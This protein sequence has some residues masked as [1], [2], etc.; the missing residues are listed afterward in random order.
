MMRE[1]DGRSKGCAFV[2]Y[3][4]KEAAN[5]ACLQ[6]NGSLILPGA[7]RNLVVKFA[8][9]SEPRNRQGAP[10]AMAAVQHVGVRYGQGNTPHSGHGMPSHM[11]GG[12]AHAAAAAGGGFSPRSSMSLAE[13][14]HWM[15]MQAATQGRAQ[16][17]AQQGGGLVSPQMVGMNGNMAV[18]P[19]MG[20]SH[21][22]MSPMGSHYGGNSM[23]GM[24]MMHPGMTSY[25][26]SYTQQ[27]NGSNFM[28]NQYTGGSAYHQQQVI[29]QVQQSHS[30]GGGAWQSDGQGAG[31]YGLIEGS[32][33]HADSAAEGGKVGAPGS[34]GCAC[35]GMGGIGMMHNGMGACGGGMGSC[36]GNGGCAFGPSGGMAM[37]DRQMGSIGFSDAMVPAGQSWDRLY[38]SNLPRPFTEAE[39][40]QLFSQFGPLV[41]VHPH[42]RPDGS[43]K[44]SFFVNFVNA[45]DGQ[46]A[47]RALHNCMLNGAMKPMTVRPST[48]R[49]KTDAHVRS[50]NVAQHATPATAAAGG[51]GS[52]NSS[53]GGAGSCNANDTHCA[54]TG[55]MGTRISSGGTGENGCDSVCAADSSDNGGGGGS[56]ESEEPSVAETPAGSPLDPHSGTPTVAAAT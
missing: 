1:K 37:L 11:A 17:M 48:S 10:A 52:G 9:P 29:E 14:G 2:R 12:V 5:Q 4:S 15:A 20:M 24:A 40:R 38:A 8:E 36:G 25:Q 16:M 47:A 44:G 23:E 33:G 54:V 56:A 21:L 18:V 27:P 3:Y 30:Q 13:G 49:R 19:N 42:K 31:S 6:L 51:G 43:N 50:A 55:E 53:A 26:P 46:K 7:A 39:V 32:H 22:G 41:D 34:Y 35:G 45:I 28:H